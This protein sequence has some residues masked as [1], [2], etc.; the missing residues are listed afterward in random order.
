MA[1]ETSRTTSVRRITAPNDESTYVDLKVIDKILFRDEKDYGQ[2]WELTFNNNLDAGRETKVV[3]IGED[4]LKVE[5]INSLFSKHDTRGIFQEWETIFDNS[6]NPPV[7][8]KTHKRKI[9]ALNKDKT[10]NKDVWIEVQRIDKIWFKDEKDNGQERIW[11]L[12][13]PDNEN[14][15]WDYTDL[16]KPDKRW[17]KTTINP[18]WRL[19]PFQTIVDCSLDSRFMLVIYH[20]NAATYHIAAIPMKNLDAPSGHVYTNRTSTTSGILHRTGWFTSCGVTQLK[21]SS[22]LH[23]AATNLRIDAEG[24]MSCL[25][26][27]S[28]DPQKRHFYNTRKTILGPAV[29]ATSPNVGIYSYGYG[30]TPKINFTGKVVYD[31]CGNS[32]NFS[33]ATPTLTVTRPWS[34]NPNA[35]A[36]VDTDGGLWGYANYDSF[37]LA[38]PFNYYLNCD[39]IV[40][41]PIQPCISEAQWN[42]FDPPNYGE[43]GYIYLW[44]G[45]AG[46]V[47]PTEGSDGL[48]RF[49]G[50]PFGDSTFTCALDQRVMVYSNN[51]S[52]DKVTVT[53]IPGTQTTL[54]SGTSTISTLDWSYAGYSGS[55]QYDFGG[56]GFTW[57]GAQRIDFAGGYYRGTS[58][59]D[60]FVSIRYPDNVWEGQYVKTPYGEQLDD[61]YQAAFQNFCANGKTSLLTV[62]MDSATKICS[63]GK[64][65]ID[66]T[67]T[68]FTALGMNKATDYVIAMML[69]IKK[70]DIDKLK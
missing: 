4:K 38:G 17:D 13:W 63:V 6:Q 62:T 26:S 28:G 37:H 42:Y 5:R 52:V 15:E 36:A 66:Y 22:D 34:I 19:D 16:P 35:V 39:I 61:N 11:E 43:P 25:D 59:S 27:P 24:N 18:P 41:S 33:S 56:I 21:I 49:V 46:V 10:K 32:V 8:Y 14:P 65:G 1:S 23:V 47:G 30:D 48:V 51:G 7:H 69:D 70:S 45:T 67:D 3:E 50:T 12:V 53:S 64:D 57:T 40:W 9:Y 58:A 29:S 60:L 2:E 31:E 55:Q 44:S 54:V 20:K 68:L